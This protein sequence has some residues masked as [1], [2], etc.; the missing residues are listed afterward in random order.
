MVATLVAIVLYPHMVITV[1]SGQVG[2]VGGLVKTKRA[3]VRQPLERLQAGD[4]GGTGKPKR[5]E[6]RQ[7]LERLQVGDVGGIEIKLRRP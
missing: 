1:P 2:D 3:E 7:P 4:A 5:A 6:V